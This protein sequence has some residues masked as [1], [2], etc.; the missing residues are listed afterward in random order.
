MTRSN[1]WAT[2]VLRSEW[3]EWR[4]GGPRSWRDRWHRL[5]RRWAFAVVGFGL[6]LVGLI[7][8]HA[9]T[10]VSLWET[11]RQVRD[12]QS[13]L[14]TL[15]AQAHS[16]AMAATAV[17]APPQPQ[18]DK[19]LWPAPGTQSLVWPQLEPVL[20]QYGVR[21]LSL[22][23]MTQSQTGVWPSQAVTLHLRAR[24]ED[25]VAA[26][27]ALNARGP[28]WGIERLRITAQHDGV[29]IDVVLRFWLFAQTV[30]LS[31]EVAGFADVLAGLGT[32][33]RPDALRPI[34]AAPVFVSTQLPLLPSSVS[35]WVSQNAEHVSAPLSDGSAVRFPG[36]Q[37]GTQNLQMPAFSPDPVDWPLDQLRVAG[38]WHQAHDE[39]LILVAGPHWVR[40][41]VGQRIGP[42]GHVVYSIQGQ[43]VH[44]RAAQGP[45]LV[46]G[47]EKVKP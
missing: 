42:D 17:N 41:S 1:R 8:L 31:S 44:L 13:Q 37:A 26:W 11:G 5:A 22:R 12:L 39:Q 24:F 40:A 14:T 34:K 19:A 7:S 21:L 4:W 27:A 16:G 47:L 20:A 43:E 38:M 23:P 3:R 30:G 32:V 33:A 15:Q 25:W 28:V 18:R 2:R 45:V 9:D 6:G 10:L 29:D 36:Q 46:I 35:A